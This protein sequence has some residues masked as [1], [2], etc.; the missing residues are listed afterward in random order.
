MISRTNSKLRYENWQQTTRENTY[1][2]RYPSYV[3]QTDG[4]PSAFAI[5]D[6]ELG[7]SHSHVLSHP[8]SG[9]II[10]PAHSGCGGA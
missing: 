6:Q 5:L 4:R 7:D 1:S 10:V 3:F 8:L 9:G 2:D